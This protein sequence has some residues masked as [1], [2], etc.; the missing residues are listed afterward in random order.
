MSRKCGSAVQ[1][2]EASLRRTFGTT[3][4]HT[5]LVMGSR[6]TDDGVEWGG[7]EEE[8]PWPH[9]ETAGRCEGI[10][11]MTGRPCTLGD[12]Q[13]YHRDATGAEWLD[14]A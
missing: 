4:E 6:T 5:H 1:V 11:P 3:A 13:G 14:D 7:S 12:H 9:L 2:P 8:T 10:N